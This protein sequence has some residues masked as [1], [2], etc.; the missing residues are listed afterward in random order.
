[1]Y[2]ALTKEQQAQVSAAYEEALKVAN[3][4]QRA[5]RTDLRRQ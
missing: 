4:V 1:M 3:R 5:I 2:E